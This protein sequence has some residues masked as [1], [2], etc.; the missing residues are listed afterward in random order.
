MVQIAHAS[1]R[2]ASIILAVHHYYFIMLLLHYAIS[3]RS[4][5]NFLPMVSSQFILITKLFQ[6][7]V[8]TWQYV[9]LVLVTQHYHSIQTSSLLIPFESCIKLKNIFLLLRLQEFSSLHK[10][11][12]L[13]VIKKRN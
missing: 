1:M 2:D 10:N 3:S 5:V 12:R 8:L 6:K 11:V 4:I 7:E 13:S 9:S